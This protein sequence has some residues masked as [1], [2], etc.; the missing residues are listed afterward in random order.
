MNIGFFRH[1]IATPRGTPEIPDAQ[2][3]LTSE[4]RK[5][6]AQAAKGLRRLDLRFDS[7]FASPLVRAMQTAE[8]LADVLGLEAPKSLDLLRPGTPPRRLLG[9]LPDLRS[10]M[11]LLVGHEPLLSSAIWVAA[12]AAG[13]SRVELK[14]AGFAL[15]R[16]E[17][18]SAPPRAVLSLL[19]TP[20][21]L[22]KLG[23]R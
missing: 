20:S 17:G 18:E 13:Q 14:K 8:I 7:V 12:G 15:L 16:S 19:L 21:V 6:T 4:G 10:K 11:P 9:E 1:G 3:P 5:K 2:R 23:S 22:R